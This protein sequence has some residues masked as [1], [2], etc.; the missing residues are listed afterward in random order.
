M[1]E[2]VVLKESELENV[3]GGFMKFCG[4]DMVM[5]Y[6]HADGT[7]TYYPILSSSAQEANKRSLILH[8]EYYNQEDLILKMLQDEGVIGQQL[9]V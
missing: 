4:G 1:S 2:K 6:T 3:Q 8:A 9:D 7:V 5:V